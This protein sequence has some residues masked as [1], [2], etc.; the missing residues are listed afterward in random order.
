MESPE[1]PVPSG[2]PGAA[3]VWFTFSKDLPDGEVVVPILTKRGTVVAVRPGEAS[4]RFLQG[5]NETAKMLIDTGVWQP[6][7][8]GTDTAGEG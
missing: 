5:L 7:D 3:R 2:K 1:Q 6:G 4:P 8:D